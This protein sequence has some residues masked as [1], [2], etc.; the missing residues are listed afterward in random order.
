MLSK[1]AR[2]VAIVSVAAAA[3]VDIGATQRPVRRDLL[4]AA[5]ASLSQLA[6]KLTQA[7]H[8]AH[9]VDIRFTFA[10]SNT[11]ARQII[12]GARID[13]FISADVAQMDAVEQAGRLADGTRF[14]L[15]GNQLALVGVAGTARVMLQPRDLVA[16]E[17]RRVA[18]GDPQAVPIGVYGKEWLQRIGVWEAVAL[19]VIPLPSS[20]AVLAAIREGRADAG[21]VYVTDTGGAGYVVPLS[22]GPRIVYPAAA[23]AGARQHDARLLLDFLKG[24]VAREVFTGARFTHLP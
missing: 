6:P 12:E 14:D 15:L 18:M 10:G 21:I 22:D 11:L 5:A 17:V 2:L 1:Y 3:L 16:S 7:F 9:G 23:I 8:D 20:P 13:V 4:V 19:K 24:R